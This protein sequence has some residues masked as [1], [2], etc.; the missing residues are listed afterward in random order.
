MLMAL[1]EQI[2]LPSGAF[3]PA[4]LNSTWRCGWIWMDLNYPNYYI[5]SVEEIKAKAM[6]QWS[7]ACSNEDHIEPPYSA[8]S[9]GLQYWSTVLGSSSM[10]FSF[11]L[12]FPSQWNQWNSPTSGNPAHLALRA[13]PSQHSNSIGFEQKPILFEPMSGIQYSTRLD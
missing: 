3:H 5:T 2:A 6:E 8:C 10:L 4:G 13:G 7:S 9:W 11:K 1:A 12:A